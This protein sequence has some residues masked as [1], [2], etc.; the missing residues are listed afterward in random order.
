MKIIILIAK[1]DFLHTTVHIPLIFWLR[2]GVVWPCYFIY[3][4]LV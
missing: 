1:Y 3:L 4:K 2:L